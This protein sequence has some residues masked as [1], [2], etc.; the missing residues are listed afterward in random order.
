MEKKKMKKNNF[1]SQLFMVHFYEY[2]YISL[3]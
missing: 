2:K 3:E 1:R